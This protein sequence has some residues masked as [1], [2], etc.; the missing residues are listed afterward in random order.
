M[1]INQYLISIVSCKK[2]YFPK[3]LIYF[4]DFKTCNYHTESVV[5]PNYPAGL[6][7]TKINTSN[8]IGG[9]LIL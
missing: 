5:V 7:Q 9:K 6:R 8:A 4:H 3:Y 2:M 1:K